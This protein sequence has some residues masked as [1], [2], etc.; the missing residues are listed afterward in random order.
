MTIETE[1]PT[2]MA[3]NVRK[4]NALVWYFL[5]KEW[6]CDTDGKCTNS[7]NFY[8]LTCVVGVNLCLNNKIIIQFGPVYLD[9]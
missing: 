3:F 2:S 9:Q 6:T 1:K 5:I 4:E 8:T 7:S